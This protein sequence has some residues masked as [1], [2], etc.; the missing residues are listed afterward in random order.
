M[1][2]LF[3]VLLHNSSTQTIM[4]IVGKKEI[5]KRRKLNPFK[6]KKNFLVR[7]VKQQNRLC[8]EVLESPSLRH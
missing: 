1:C 7:V 2:A 8:R 6:H 5:S 4:I 3:I